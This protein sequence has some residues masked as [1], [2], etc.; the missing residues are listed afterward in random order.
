MTSLKTRKPKSSDVSLDTKKL[1]TLFE[2]KS[3]PKAA[4]FGVIL[5][6]DFL[7]CGDSQGDRIAVCVSVD[8]NGGD[9]YVQVFGHTG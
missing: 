2:E 5:A 1:A 8:P 6:R 3:R 4:F 9:R 7:K